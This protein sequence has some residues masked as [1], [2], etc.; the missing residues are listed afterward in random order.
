MIKKSYTKNIG[1]PSKHYYHQK[2]KGST[3]RIL[4]TKVEKKLPLAEIGEIGSAGEKRH[5]H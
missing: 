4:G 1:Q 3:K 5:E 2:E